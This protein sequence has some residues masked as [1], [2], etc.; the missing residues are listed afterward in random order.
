MAAY[1]GLLKEKE[2]LEAALTPASAHD[3]GTAKA[4]VVD[5]QSKKAAVTSSSIPADSAVL[6]LNKQ[7][8]TLM[9]SLATLSAEKSRMEASFQA[10]KRQLRQELQARDQ[11]I[12]QLQ[13]KLKAEAAASLLDVEKVKSRL[14]IER[15]TRDKEITD[16]MAMVKELQ[17]LITD[18]RLLKTN[19][20]M[21]LNDLKQQWSQLDGA[22]TSHHVDLQA[23]LQQTRRKY[24]ELKSSMR[25]QQA[26]SAA[27]L[28]SETSSN[29]EMLQHLQKDM[30]N[31]R[32]QT[33]RTVLHEQKRAQ[34]A[35][36]R[37]KRLASA[38]EERVVTLEAR[39]AELSGTVGTYD[40]LRQSDQEQIFRL[41]EQIAQLELSSAGG[42]SIHPPGNAISH[43]GAP[44]KDIGE[45]IEEAYQIKKLVILENAR[46][47]AP[48]D[49]SKLF[50]TTNDHHDCT[51]ALH[52]LRVELERGRLDADTM[53]STVDTQKSHMRTLQDKIQ[54]LNRNIDEQEQELKHMSTAHYAELHAERA[55]WKELV[56]SMEMDFRA[57]V[58]DLEMQLQKQRERS[59]TLLE[60]KE[61]EIRNVKQ[62][63]DQQS[64]AGGATDVGAH[65]RRKISGTAQCDVSASDAPTAECHML[66][67]VHE[68]SR[69]EVDIVALRK[70]KNAA[71]ASLRQA[72]QDKVTTQ[73]ELHD[74]IG[75]LEYNVDR[76]ERCKSRESANLEYL[77]NVVLS[78]LTAADVD[79]RRHMVNAIGAVLQFS[80]AEL[81]TIGG[82]LAG[83]K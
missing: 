48:R 45:L 6:D 73:Q 25:A 42:K 81:N 23:E 49:L 36:E 41:K 80:P 13:D 24:R 37:S 76:L 22:D 16:H 72:L 55:K 26:S 74:R 8:A 1:K 9:N 79:S 5:D 33:H 63:V 35:E 34:Q 11:N 59:L 67:F 52:E 4:T 21:Q 68:L 56:A 30:E 31:L 2:A 69:K 62:S 7:I 75:D 51:E 77:K 64:Y 19:L 71:E 18:E 28:T 54:V 39:L 12:R 70:S 29:D 15:H 32:L 20:E 83:R 66:H 38:N 10:D 46:Q 60:E 78:F 40:R 58:G 65:T 17:K 27:H 50:A 44:T 43:T 61:L 53:R 3:G 82:F 57:K 14:I 47:S